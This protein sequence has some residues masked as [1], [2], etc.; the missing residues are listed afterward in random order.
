MHP[1]TE[2]S[3]AAILNV[4]ASHPFSDK[5]IPPPIREHVLTGTQYK[6]DFAFRTTQGGWL[7]IE[8]D[9]A[10]RCLG[11]FIKHW[12]WAEDHPDQPVSLIHLVGRG[13]GQRLLLTFIQEKAHSKL[14]H[15]RSVV[16]VVQDWKSHEW[17]SDLK[18]A[19]RSLPP[20]SGT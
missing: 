9:D 15:F 4:F 11:N 3:K 20:F 14:E 13:I 6:S 18:S 10:Q 2:E 7:F 12:Q 16:V 5:L 17:V 1:G 8:D 19:A